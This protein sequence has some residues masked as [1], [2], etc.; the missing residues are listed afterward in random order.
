MANVAVAVSAHGYGHEG[1]FDYR[2]FKT[3]HIVIKPKNGKEFL[4][5]LS[6]IS[7]TNGPIYLM[8][9]FSHSYPRGIIMTNWSGFYDEPGPNDTPKAAYIS[10]MVELINK[11]EILFS[12]NPQIMLFGCNLAGNFAEKLS[13]AVSGTVIAPRGDSYPEIR[14]NQETGIF[15][16]VTQ[17]EV[18]I[19]GRYAYS[20]GKRLRAW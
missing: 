16:A 17:W 18:Y 9:V 4:K 2:A 13:A 8:K 7:K 3:G 20:A 15:I 10:D 12:S 19:K 11:R 1:A 5:M 14:G 6:D